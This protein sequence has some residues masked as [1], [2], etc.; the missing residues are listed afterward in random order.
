MS[1]AINQV[2]PPVESPP[3]P[4][5]G[6]I[7]GLRMPNSCMVYRVLSEISSLQIGDQVM[8]ESREGEVIATVLHLFSHEVELYPGPVKKVLRRLTDKDQKFI[9]WRQEHELKAQL[10][11]RE[12]IREMNLSMKLSKVTYLSGG[13]KAVIHF[14]SESRVDFRDLVRVLSSELKVRVEMR[15]VGV[16]DESKLLCGMGSCGKTLCCSEYLSKFHPVSV[17][18]AKNQDLSLTP[19]GISGVCGRLMCCLAYENDTYLAQRKCMPKLKGRV[20]LQDGREATVR[21]VYPMLNLV[22]LQFGDGAIEKMAPSLLSGDFATKAMNEPIVEGDEQAEAEPTKQPVVP[23]RQNRNAS[24]TEK[25]PRRSE[26]EK[27]RRS[28][29]ASRKPAVS[30]QP[31]ASVQPPQQASSGEEPVVT[32]LEENTATPPVKKRSTRRRRR[33]NRGGL[34]ASGCAVTAPANESGS[35]EGNA[36]AKTSPASGRTNTPSAGEAS[37]G[38]GGE[39]ARTPS[40]GRRRRRSPS[41]RPAEGGRGVSSASTG[42]GEGS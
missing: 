6:T 32:S 41:R 28:N 29:T 15:H 26:P 39:T 21:A 2:E 35:A 12:K 24:T 7:L 31:T 1:S 13:G 10:L 19:E 22:E 18:M 4:P 33:N 16:R 17:R 14:T 27:N 5:K 37:S 23:P 34:T 3:L 40:R 8:V 30:T 9:L 36:V 20:T 38:E 25:A 11:C 42:G